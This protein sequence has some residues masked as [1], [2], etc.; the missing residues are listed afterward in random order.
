MTASTLKKALIVSLIAAIIIAAIV[1]QFFQ[2]D[3][4]ERTL[5]LEGIMG[6]TCEIYVHAPFENP[7]AYSTGPEAAEKALRQ[8]EVLMSASMQLSAMSAVNG[9]PAGE[10]IHCPA[11]LMDVLHAAKNAHEETGGAFDVTIAPLI[12]IWKLAGRA[13]T[14]PD[15]AELLAAR[16]A[17]S[18]ADF[19]LGLDTVTKARPTATLDLGGIAKGYGIDLAID[20]MIETGADAGWVN[21]GGDL[22]FFGP[23]PNGPDWSISVQS[24]FDPDQ[25]IGS[26]HIPEGAVCTSGDYERYSTIEGE[27]FSHIIDPRTG[28]PSRVSPS[29]TVVAPTAMQADVWATALSVLGVAGLDTLPEGVHAMIII[30]DDADF[31][32]FMSEGF[33]EL[34][35]P[36]GG[37]SEAPAE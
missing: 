36:I 8:T 15:D 32:P 17:S 26:V 9:A 19:Q 23:N 10:P 2:P 33:E 13:D 21:V 4:I 6:T 12:E 31:E 29:V 20:A 28:W 14:L 30:G 35:I 7:I 25:R 27:Q 1:L 16:D 11:P 5:E 3:S 22:R 34:F 24:P 18:W 37:I